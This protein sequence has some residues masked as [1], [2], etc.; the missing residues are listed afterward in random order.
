MRS[1]FK[2]RFWRRA[3]LCGLRSRSSEQVAHGNEGPLTQTSGRNLGFLDR[4]RRPKLTDGG[5]LN[6][7][8]WRCSRLP[9]LARYAWSA[10]DADRESSAPPG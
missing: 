9:L 3:A 5:S 4:D 6:F 8:F 2:F 1:A 10:S 7:P